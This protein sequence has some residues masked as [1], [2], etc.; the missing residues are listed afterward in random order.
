MLAPKSHKCIFIGYSE[1]SKVYRLFD[2]SKQSVII[3][4]DVQFIEISTPPKFVEP[5]VTLNI[6]LSPVTPISVTPSS[7]LT[8]LS[9]PS[10][11]SSSIPLECIKYP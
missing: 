6:P 10:S 3:R 2:P 7:S 1:D 5:H 4:R 9:S 11:S 8:D